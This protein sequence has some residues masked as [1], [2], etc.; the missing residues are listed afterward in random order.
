MTSGID[1]IRR[2]AESSLGELPE[3]IGLLAGCDEAA[4]VEQFNENIALYLGRD[5]IP[6]KVA[7]LAAMAVAA[8]NGPK[9]SAML[10]YKLARRFGADPLEVVDAL[11][12]AKMALM[13]STLSAVSDLVG[14]GDVMDDEAARIL[15]EF[16]RKVGPA[17]ARVRDLA[18]FSKYLLKEHLRERGGAHINPRKLE[19]KYAI[20][21]AFAVSVSI[22]DRECEEVYRK[23]FLRNGG[24]EEEYKDA[25]MIARFITGNRAFVNGID[26]LRSTCR[27]STG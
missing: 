24:R 26:I 7:A 3:V 1:E 22:R 8:A 10:H 17:P 12:A 21:I 19:Q 13:S 6:K 27:P 9:E 18:R 16:E 14:P 5:N 20:L 25:M 4:A 2:F 23:A 15:G 11:R